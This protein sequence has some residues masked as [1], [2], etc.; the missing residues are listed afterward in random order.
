VRGADDG[1]AGRERDNKSGDTD[2]NRFAQVAPGLR[3][4]ARLVVGYFFFRSRVKG[5]E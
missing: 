4:L 1:A 5:V 3:R 2:K